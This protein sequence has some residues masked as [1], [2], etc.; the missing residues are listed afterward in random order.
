MLWESNQLGSSNAR[1]LINTIWWNNCLH[2]GMR[3]REEHYSINM[4][5]FKIEIDGMDRKFISYEEGVTKTR[6]AGFNFQERLIKRKMYA[7]GDVNCP[8]KTFLFFKSRRPEALRESGPFYLCPIDNP[9]SNVWFKTQRVGINSINNILKNMKKNS[10]LASL[11]PN[12]K[13]S[14]HSARKTA[15][16]K[17]KSAGFQKCEIKNITGHANEKGLDPY[18]SG[19]E[20][21]MFKMS[22]AIH[23]NHNQQMPSSSTHGKQTP[24]VSSSTVTCPTSFDFGV[25]WSEKTANHPFIF[26]NC[27]VTIMQQANSTPNRDTSIVTKGKSTAPRRRRLI[28]ESDSDN[29]Q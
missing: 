2:F 27:N 13:I 5:D 8:V 3:G 1:A 6:K 14:N 17:M 29:S 24:L 4:E 15:V 20:N 9:K 12:K 28:I 23:N 16:R 22:S 21:E 18:D 26:N 19:N 11:I 10:P 25:N 7:S